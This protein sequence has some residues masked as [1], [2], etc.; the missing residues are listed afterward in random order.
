MAKHNIVKLSNIDDHVVFVV[1]F[2]F[3]PTKFTI[4]WKSRKKKRNGKNIRRKRK[5]IRKAMVKI[6]N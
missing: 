1:C 3:C 2:F 6:C 5:K 4:R